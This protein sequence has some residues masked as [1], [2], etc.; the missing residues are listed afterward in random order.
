MF[1]VHSDLLNFG[2][3]VQDLGANYPG[4]KQVS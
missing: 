3:R 1:R 4:D 2:I